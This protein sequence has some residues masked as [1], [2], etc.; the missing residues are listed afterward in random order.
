MVF[1]PQCRKTP[2]E[3]GD[4]IDNDCDGLIDEEIR[5]GKDNDGDGIADEDIEKVNHLLH[6]SQHI[7]HLLHMGCSCH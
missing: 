3:P 4:G 5:D 2:P 1:R 7:M 6:L